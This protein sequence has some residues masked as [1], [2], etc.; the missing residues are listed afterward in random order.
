MKRCFALITALL[1]IVVSLA[2]CGS[3][4]DKKAATY[5]GTTKDVDLNAMMEQINTQFGLTGLKN[6]T[7][8]A[9]YYGISAED[10]KQFYAE[11]P[12]ED[13]DFVEL[14]ICEA[15][16]PD[17]VSRIE[18]RLNNR[19]DSQYNTAKSYS[20]EDLEMVNNCKVVVNGKYIYLVISPNAAAISA[21]IEQAIN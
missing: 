5:N 19:L 10:V 12:A 7:D 13:K 16:S 17:A 8:S 2:A 11:M 20:K 3:D 4:G 1:L 21:A 9:R 6:V 15:M 18:K 14:V